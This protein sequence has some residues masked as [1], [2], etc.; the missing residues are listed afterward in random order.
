M[1]S[2]QQMEITP[3]RLS[4]DRFY[5]LD[6]MRGL[7]AI[8]VVA[9]HGLG[10][11]DASKAL[12]HANLAVDFFF[13]LSAFVIA[14]AYTNK[15]YAGMT[16]RNF[17]LVRWIRLFPL[18][19]MGLMMGLLVFLLKTRMGGTSGHWEATFEVFS[20]ALFFLPSNIDLAPGWTAGFP[21]NVPA[22]SLFFEWLANI[23]WI[24]F[25]FRLSF[26]KLILSTTMLAAA[27]FWQAAYFS[28]VGGGDN[29]ASLHH[30]L[31]RVAFPFM[32]GLLAWRM[33]TDGSVDGQYKSNSAATILTLLLLFILCA[34]VGT[35]KGIR[36]YYEAAAVCLAFPAIIYF[37]AKIKTSMNVQAI[38]NW[39]GLIS[40]PLYITHHSIIR[41]LSNW[42]R[43]HDPN[44]SSVAALVTIEV[45]I[46]MLVAHAL[47]RLWD[48]PVRR[49]LSAILLK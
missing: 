8:C 37:G 2:G 46:S 27:Y 10:A 17:L 16:I 26:S 34:N 25:L 35:N 49:K 32:A 20:L 23:A 1:L 38:L 4:G 21:L 47:T 39:L 31:A 42:A 15:A 41:I 19:L 13:M 11:F 28:G 18:H 44:P 45:G 9:Y 14:Q 30:G 5:V 43:Q 40:Y 36:G 3:P 22:W 24:I 6:G 29:I 7:V 48:E 33:Y 12:G